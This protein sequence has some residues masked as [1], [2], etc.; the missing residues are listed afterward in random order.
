MDREMFAHRH[1][2]IGDKVLRFV[3]SRPNGYYCDLRGRHAGHGQ[4]IKPPNLYSS[5]LDEAHTYI[6]APT[7]APCGPFNPSLF[8][9]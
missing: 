3:G 6:H 2:R 8:A 5:S 4:R 9:R 1:F 7:Q